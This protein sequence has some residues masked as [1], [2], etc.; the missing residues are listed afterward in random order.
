M[1]EDLSKA[2]QYQ[3][4]Q[5]RK[6]LEETLGE[7]VSTD[8]ATA[9]WL[10]HHADQ[11]RQQRQEHMLEMQ[12]EEIARYRWIRSEEAHCDLGRQAALEWV[13]KYAKEWRQWYEDHHEKVG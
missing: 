11:W 12:R 8:T 5:H 9:S 3:V 10:A 6:A 4:E 7:V 2:E 13:Q 1:S